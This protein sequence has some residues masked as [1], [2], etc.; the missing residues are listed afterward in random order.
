M[1]K[2][3]TRQ[4]EIVQIGLLRWWAMEV[5]CLANQQH[6]LPTLEKSKE[7]ILFQQLKDNAEE[8]ESKEQ[9]FRLTFHIK[10]M[11]YLNEQGLILKGRFANTIYLSALL[12]DLLHLSFTSL[13]W[14]FNQ[15]LISLFINHEWVNWLI[16]N[17]NG[18]IRKQPL[19]CFQYPPLRLLSQ[20]NPDVFSNTLCSE[21]REKEKPGLEF[22]RSFN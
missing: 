4:A 17:R 20:Y 15:E 21:L 12:N 6:F 7:N 3:G 16:R 14:P 1:V 13:P 18:F 2:K 11:R 9:M 5:G 10:A 8:T 19:I 22:L